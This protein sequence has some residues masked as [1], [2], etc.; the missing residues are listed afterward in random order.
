MLYNRIMDLA[1]GEIK[2]EEIIRF[3]EKYSTSP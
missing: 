1:K 2:K 3:Y